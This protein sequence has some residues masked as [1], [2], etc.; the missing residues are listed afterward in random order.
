MSSLK[1]IEE[2]TVLI[3]TIYFFQ[4]LQVAYGKVEE[5]D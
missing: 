5:K 3:M 1:K 4:L 2:G